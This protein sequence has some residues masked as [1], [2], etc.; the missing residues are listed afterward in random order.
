[1]IV[2]IDNY[3]SFTYNLAQL[4]QSLG[5][6]VRV[7]R[8][9]AC[10]AREVFALKPSHL[11]ISPG[12]SSPQNA[13]ISVEL[14]RESMIP[15]LGVCLGHQALAVAFGGHV[16]HAPRPMHGF[17]SMITHSQRGIFAGISQNFVA[18]RY[19]SLC[20]SEQSL[21]ACLQVTARVSDE[22]SVLMAIEHRERPLVGVQ[23]HPESVLST[24]G[25]AIVR[26]FLR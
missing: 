11:V 18:A 7:L 21:P 14:L 5:A 16:Q 3:D 12:P 15:T 17:A 10:S 8:N 1:V 19:H 20:V 24:E 9:D 23:F 6:T 13:G 26:N 2:L 22:H 25:P 4:L